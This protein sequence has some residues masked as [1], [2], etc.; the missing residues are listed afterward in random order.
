MLND[1]P[2]HKLSNGLI[3]THLVFLWEV[4]QKYNAHCRKKSW[5]I[6]FSGTWWKSISHVNRRRMFIIRALLTVY[7]GI[8][9]HIPDSKVHGANMGPTWVL[10]V[11]D[12]PHV[13]PMNLAIR[14]ITYRRLCA[15]HPKKYAYVLH[16]YSSGWVKW[17]LEDRFYA[18]EAFMGIMCR[19]NLWL[20]KL[21]RTQKP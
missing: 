20:T 7:Q 13:D 18:S 2:C 5:H 6:L 3:A 17:R 4:H 15:A 11:P 12:G 21:P 14:D 19:V 10:S 8:C 16:W 9:K 1:P